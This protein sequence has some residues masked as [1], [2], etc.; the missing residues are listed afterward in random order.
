M[1]PFLNDPKIS[2]VIVAKVVSSLGFFELIVGNRSTQ[3][4]CPCWITSARV[5][6][7]LSYSAFCFQRE[8]L[9]GATPLLLWFQR[10]VPNP[11]AGSTHRWATLASASNPVVVLITVPLCSSIREGIS[12]WRRFD[13]LGI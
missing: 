10:V 3:T 1:S 2:I 7:C 12:E 5:R 13:E 4:C 8:F 9:F 6:S 11:F